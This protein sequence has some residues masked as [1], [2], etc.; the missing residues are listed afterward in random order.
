MG[1]EQDNIMRYL[2]K[3]MKELITR[4]KLNTS[5][6]GLLQFPSEENLSGGV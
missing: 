4:N 2:G 5:K 6:S 1:V 3:V